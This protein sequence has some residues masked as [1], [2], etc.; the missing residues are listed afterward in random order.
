M[1][2]MGANEDYRFG[3]LAVHIVGLEVTHVNN[4]QTTSPKRNETNKL[5]IPKKIEKESNK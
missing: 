3:R 2:A 4:V 5:H 1:A